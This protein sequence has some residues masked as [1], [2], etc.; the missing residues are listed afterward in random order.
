MK[1]L[2]YGLRYDIVANWRLS[3]PLVELG[4]TCTEKEEKDLRLSSLLLS[5]GRVDDVE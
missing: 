5:T 3:K 1:I 4:H 2:H